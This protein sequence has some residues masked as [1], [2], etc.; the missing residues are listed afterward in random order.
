MADPAW[1]KS[2]KISISKNYESTSKETGK[3]ILTQHNGLGEL[4]LRLEPTLAD[5]GQATA[6]GLTIHHSQSCVKFIY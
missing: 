2:L 1:V 4:L 6:T 5:N 3:A